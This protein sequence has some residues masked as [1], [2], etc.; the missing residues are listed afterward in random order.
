MFGTDLDDDG[1]AARA[2][3]LRQRGDAGRSTSRSRASGAAVDPQ[4]LGPAAARRRRPGRR[5]RTPNIAHLEASPGGAVTVVDLDTGHDAMLS[6]PVELAAIIDGIAAAARPDEG[7][8]LG[9]TACRSG[10]P[11]TT[12][13]CTRPSAAG[14]QRHCPPSVP[15]AVLDAEREERPDVLER[16][17][18]P[19]LAGP[20]R[21]GGRRR[22]GLRR[23]PSWSS[24]SRSWPTPRPPGRCC[25]RTLATAVVGRV[26]ERRAARRGAPCARGGGAGRRGGRRG[27][28]PAGQRRPP[29]AGGSRAL[30]GRC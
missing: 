16:P 18:R 5:R 21:A 12:T 1:H 15:R 8:R 6:R 9:S 17:R 11:K 27:L 3:P 14:S 26:G 29:E 7:V 23:S 10:S 2:R 25:R 28:G 19:G 4:D 22:L 24:C 30:R 20:A 13:R